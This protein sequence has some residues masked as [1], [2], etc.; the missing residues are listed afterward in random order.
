MKRYFIFLCLMLTLSIA[1]AA[2]GDDDP[3]PVPETEQPA[4][5]E[6]PGE[7]DGNDNPDTP[8]SDDTPDTP[9][10]DEPGNN[11]N[12]NNDAPMSNQLT[13]TVGTA[14]FT[15]TFADNAT[16]TAFK[17]RLP[18]TLNMS[19]LNGNEKYFY[20]PESLPAA[21]SNPGTIQA[22]DL[23]LYGSDCL[24]LFY[25]TFRTSYSYT[26]IG[27]IDN[28]SRLAAALG[29]ESVSVIFSL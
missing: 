1:F 21:A 8:G 13:I 6:S 16:A 27:R 10:Q 17:S 20:L 28:P 19:E 22:G 14:S 2:C 29:Q 12:N 3:V 4:T 18:L 9:G 24:V 15:A 23:M 7:P 5:P 11:N 26:R 25:E